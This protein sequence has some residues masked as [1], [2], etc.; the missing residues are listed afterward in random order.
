[1]AQDHEHDSESAPLP[2]LL[3]LPP[4]ML[5]KIASFVDSGGL[6]VAI[7]GAKEPGDAGSSSRL[8][9]R[10]GVD[11]AERSRFGGW[12]GLLGGDALVAAAGCGR[13]GG[14]EEED[15]AHRRRASA[16]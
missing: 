6:V 7:Y 12:P 5:H 8:A 4:E 16:S 10:A 13:A 1:M 9:V 14:E 11:D 3:Q 2:A 15:Q